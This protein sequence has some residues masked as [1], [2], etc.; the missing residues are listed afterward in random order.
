MAPSLGH[1]LL[2]RGQLSKG[3][4]KGKKTGVLIDTTFRTPSLV[5]CVFPFLLLYRSH[6]KTQQ[7]KAV[8]LYSWPC[9]ARLWTGPVGGLAS[10]L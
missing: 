5:S 3:P 6:S 10:T 4:M 7:H 2:K 8:L 9:G 1:Y